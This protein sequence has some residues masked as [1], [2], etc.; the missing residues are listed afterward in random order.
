MRKEQRQSMQESSSN[1]GP[2]DSRIAELHQQL[3]P[4]REEH[5]KLKSEAREWAEKRN[6]LHRQIKMLRAKGQD[7]K[8][9]RD[10]L[11]KRVQELKTLREEAHKSRNEKHARIV[12]LREELRTITPKRPSSDMASLQT[13]IQKLEWKIQTTPLALKE[14]EK[15][16]NQI[17]SL[18]SQLLVHK[19]LQRLKKNLAGLQIEEK[20]MESRA[21]AYH[22]EILALAEHS[23]DLHKEM[24]EALDKAGTLQR[25][26]DGIH[27]AFLETKQKTQCLH[28]RVELIREELRCVEDEERAKHELELQKGFEKQALEKLKRGEKL[29]L[30]EFK[31]LSEKGII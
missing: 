31:V 12:K 22:T 9:E 28:K 25:E 8:L 6:S 14:E 29:T 5:D 3:A 18:E 13:E 17:G 19:K 1:K 24:L 16:I 20:E 2:K 4:L 7:L 26:A 30:E 23:Q 21:E 27:E 15:L 10:T 11:N